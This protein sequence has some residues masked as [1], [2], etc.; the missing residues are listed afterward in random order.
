MNKNVIEIIS[1]GSGRIGIRGLSCETQTDMWSSVGGLTPH[2]RHAVIA[3]EIPKDGKAETKEVAMEE[4]K[5]KEKV[6]CHSCN[7]LCTPIKANHEY[8]C[9]HSLNTR[10]E[11]NWLGERCVR[12]AKPCD[13]NKNNDCKWYESVFESVRAAKIKKEG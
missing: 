11:V 7:H 6:F 9:L 13:I 3:V 1:N 5:T 8:A 12:I 10:V 2:R 4:A